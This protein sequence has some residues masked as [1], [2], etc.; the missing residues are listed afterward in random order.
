[1]RI[2]LTG[3]TGF[4]GLNVAQELLRA[5]HQVVGLA[6]SQTG[7]ERLAAIGASAF[8]GDLDRAESLTEGARGC[9]GVIHTA[10]DHDFSN[11]AANCEKD[12]RIIEALGTALNG[13]QRP[14]IITSIT[15]FGTMEPGKP[16]IEDHFDS[17][18]PSPR[19]LSERAGRSLLD[20]GLNISFV[21][22]SQIHD[23]RKQGLVTEL[24]TLARKT[25]VSAMV[26]DGACRWSAAPVKDT[27]RLYRLA[28]ERQSAG[29]CYHAVAEDG[30]PL[31]AIAAAVGER[32]ALPVASLHGNA[33][34]T[35]FGWL[36]HFMQSDMYASGEATR[37][38]LDWHPAGPG[39]LDD[40]R[41]LEEEEAA[42]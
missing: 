35:H 21:R 8:H 5:G 38:R 29:G 22:L 26:G 39:L 20:R 36:S 1:M 7:A 15:A 24:I 18:Y 6:R 4:I 13:S 12:A 16:A 34:A 9:D 19:I 28:L 40:I 3:A 31:H 42:A 23:T 11:Y 2:F 41:G 37:R 30:I 25:G 33:A 32:L 17:H 27:A 10:F 14:L